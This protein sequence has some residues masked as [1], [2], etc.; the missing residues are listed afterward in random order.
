M[1]LIR[2]AKYATLLGVGGTSLHVL[3]RNDW[4]VISV[5]QLM[6]LTVDML[7]KDARNIGVVRMGR[8]AVTVSQIA[9]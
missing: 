6:L 7:Y 8:A 4:Y 9:V 5:S 3:H 2:A 1:A